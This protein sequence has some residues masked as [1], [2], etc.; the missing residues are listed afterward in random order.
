MGRRRTEQIKRTDGEE[1]LNSSVLWESKN[2]DKVLGNEKT[3]QLGDSSKFIP[4]NVSV[5][6]EGSMA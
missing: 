6:Q 4:A 5:H 2:Q 3:L 1:N